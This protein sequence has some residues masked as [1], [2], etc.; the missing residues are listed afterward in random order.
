MSEFE[1]KGS[2]KGVPIRS[3]AKE[4]SDAHRHRQQFCQA[5]VDNLNQRF[6]EA[7]DVAKSITVLD[8]TL[9]PEEQEERLLYGEVEVKKLSKALGLNS[10]AVLDQFRKLKA[11][12]SEGE[13][14]KSFKNDLTCLPIS[15]AECERGFS[16]MNLARCKLRNALAISRVSQLLFLKINGPQLNKFNAAKYVGSWIRKGHR[17][18]T[19]QNRRLTATDPEDVKCR[20]FM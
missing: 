1:E 6:T 7:T 15:T 11:G 2:F 18:A 13:I 9:W 5:L 19:A 4:R 3:N 12:R 17:S 16:E 14:F 8:R 10:G 20:V